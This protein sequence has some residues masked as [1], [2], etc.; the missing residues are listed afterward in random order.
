MS[1]DAEYLL[2]FQHLESIVNADPHLVADQTAIAALRRLPK[3]DYLA[4]RKQLS[5]EVCKAAV[6]LRDGCQEQL[7]S[8]PWRQGALVVAGDSITADLQSW[9][10]I[11]CA[12]MR[13]SATHESS[14]VVNFALDGDTSTGLLSRLP[15]IVAEQPAHVLIMIGSNDGQGHACDAMPWVSDAETERN[16][17]AIGAEVR[18]AGASVS[19]VAPPPIRVTEIESHWYLGALP[20]GWSIDRHEAKRRIVMRQEGFVYDAAAAIGDRE[21]D[22]LDGLHPSLE[23]HS[24]LAEGVVQAFAEAS[25]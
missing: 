24:R 10:R 13:A 23:G 21:Q 6:R 19:W 12:A 22:F 11:L 1:T 2:R 15:A 25:T 9:A 18:R 7:D 14:R 3:E 20:I 5:D 4:T 8:L 16:L 17:E